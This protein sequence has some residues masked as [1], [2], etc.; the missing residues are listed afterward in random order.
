[1]ACGSAEPRGAGPVTS[2]ATGGSS[3]ASGTGGSAGNGGA[4]SGPARPFADHKAPYANGTSLPSGAQTDLDRAASDWYDQWKASYLEQ[5]CGDGRFYVLASFDGQNLSLSEATGFGMIISVLMAG[6]D[7]DAKAHFDGLDRFRKDHP[8]TKS[9]ELMAWY[10]A[11]DCKSS[12]D[13][14]STADAD[15]D[16][17]LALLMADT[18][19]G[20]CG[21][22]DYRGEALGMIGAIAAAEVDTTQ[23]FMLVSNEL[24][25][26]G[27]F[28]WS[29][30]SRSAD[31]MPDHFAAFA[32]ASPTAASLWSGLAD[33][34]YGVLSA[35]QADFAP[36]SALLPDIFLGPRES[37]EPATDSLDPQG[38]P[39]HNDAYYYIASR[40]PWRVGTQAALSGETRARDLVAP[41]GAWF[42]RNTAGDPGKI[43][44]GY[45]LDGSSLGVDYAYPTMAFIAPLGVA[46]MSDPRAPAWLDAIFGTMKSFASEAYYEDSVKLLA[47][48]VMSGNWWVPESAARTCAA[49]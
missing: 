17:A 10:Q 37:P 21:D 1:V 32:A 23:N 41:I 47:M 8:T 6:H 31:F 44:A 3:P 29:N 18:Q 27:A 33:R 22:I 28:S 24:P 49:P 40:V 26:A 42:A 9:P 19:W 36:A 14:T 35:L 12:G 39:Y 30:A 7:P 13:L 34:G 5:G 16:Q 2:H 38:K 4:A 11:L 45:A 20:S 15:L 25:A 48:L 43:G 46:A